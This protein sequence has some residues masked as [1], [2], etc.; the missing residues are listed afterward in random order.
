MPTYDLNLL[1]ALDV[2]LSEGS[3]SGAAQRLHLSNS[4]MS[5]TLS[6]IRD[7]FGDPILVRAGRSLVPT[8]RAL[9]LKERLRSILDQAETLRRTSSDPDLQALN[10]RFTIRAN[11]GFIF[12]FG[13]KLL[14]V[15]AQEAPAVRLCFA[16]KAQ[17][18][19]KAL[20]EGRIDL[21]VGVL[22]DSGPEIRC[23][24][25]L[26]DRFVGV[27]GPSHELASNGP[28]TAE[29]YAAQRHISVSRRGVVQGP[30]DEA[31]RALGLT[32]EVAVTVPSFPSAL[33]LVRN[34][35]Y[36]ANVPERQT[37]TARAGLFT[38]PLPFTTETVVVSM[39]WHPRSDAD[40]AH[41]WLRSR[42]REVCSG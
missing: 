39:M 7:T 19:P 28:V 36:V 13:A 26:R 40:P 14:E 2:L 29:Q 33:A 42:V 37:M 32:R 3:V 17:K 20:R 24:A 22:G 41:R 38:F 35:A 12:E 21:D 1:A 10:Q 4:A 31:L 5:R 11:E 27:T 30:I 34:S 25:L 18:D 16:V 6:R 9:E 23:Q 15:I 8:P